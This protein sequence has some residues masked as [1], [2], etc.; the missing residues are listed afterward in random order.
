MLIKPA[1]ENFLIAYSNQIKTLLSYTR[2]L[3][4]AKIN[5]CSVYVMAMV[6]MDISSLILLK[7][8]FLVKS[9]KNSFYLIFIENIEM[10]YK[11]ARHL[12]NEHIG[13]LIR[14]GF[15]KTNRQLLNSYVDVQFSGTTV[16]AVTIIGTHLWCANVG[17]S[18]AI[19][20]KCRNNYWTAFPL[21]DDHKP[22]KPEER[23]RILK[24]G[25]RVEQLKNLMG[26]PVGPH[27]IWLKNQDAPGLAMSRSFGDT[28]AGRVGKIAEAG[29]KS[30]VIV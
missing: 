25:G 27:R 7:L 16:V 13:E 3:L 19:L 12:D 1:Q 17:D 10:A 24:Y 29:I 2:I 30:Y 14:Q 11:A 23:E 20:G 18:R 4:E 22:N 5:M 15:S 26:E 6:A 28:G 9:P 21:S 8:T